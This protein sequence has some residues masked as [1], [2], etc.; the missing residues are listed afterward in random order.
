M[1][2]CLQGKSDLI[3]YAFNL[4]SEQIKLSGIFVDGTDNSL[5]GKMK[6]GFK[7]ERRRGSESCT[8][9]AS[10]AFWSKMIYDV[11]SPYYQSYLTT[12][13]AARA[14]RGR[15]DKVPRAAPIRNGPREMI[16]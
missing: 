15:G 12:S 4:T 10:A 14:G 13:G 8:G 7:G 1:P 3:Q 5:F 9:K 11:K 16:E 2:P 6:T